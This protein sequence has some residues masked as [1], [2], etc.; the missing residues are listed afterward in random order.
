MTYGWSNQMVTWMTGEFE[1]LNRKDII[2]LKKEHS[3]HIKH[4]E[5]YSKT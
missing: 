1:I 5:N 3:E 4:N 2:K